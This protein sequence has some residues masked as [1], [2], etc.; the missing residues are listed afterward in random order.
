MQ[1]G[2]QQTFLDKKNL[3]LATSIKQATSAK[4]KQVFMT[5]IADG[6][7]SDYFSQ[8]SKLASGDG[9]L[10]GI[11]ETQYCVVGNFYYS[12]GLAG[13]GCTEIRILSEGTQLVCGIPMHKVPGISLKQK[14]DSLDQ[15]TTEDLLVTLKKDG[16][17]HYAEEAGSA[18]A[19]PSG[20][21]I[22]TRANSGSYIRFSTMS[23]AEELR[24]VSASVD[25]LVKSYPALQRTTY[26][27]WKTVLDEK[28]SD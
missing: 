19:I 3:I 18:L 25:A 1:S 9:Q 10:E 11:F 2:A 22:L 8:V 7:G 5:T 17:I 14:I 12:I 27:K 16:F 28:N 15:S 23:D 6:E 21:L 20:W 4:M 24:M 26:K 13:Y